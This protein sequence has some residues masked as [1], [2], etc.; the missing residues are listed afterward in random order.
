MRDRLV[1]STDPKSLIMVGCKNTPV[2]HCKNFT[3]CRNGCIGISD[4]LI[5]YESVNKLK[6]DVFRRYGGGPCGSQMAHVIGQLFTNWHKPRTDVITGI[7][8][9]LTRFRLG[10]LPNIDRIENIFREF[11]QNFTTNV[12][13]LRSLIDKI[14]R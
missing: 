8:G 1:P 14:A 12:N 11:K 4:V 7:R 10:A 13:N 2:V 5:N 6:E 9:V 3:K